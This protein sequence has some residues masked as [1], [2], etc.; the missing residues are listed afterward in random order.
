MVFKT[1]KIRTHVPHETCV[2]E[3]VLLK[4]IL[5]LRKL[6]KPGFE[7]N[8]VSD[9]ILEIP[10]TSSGRAAGLTEG[11]CPGAVNF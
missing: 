8:S 1:F 3:E 5:L 6:N 10:T 11:N 4:H 2:R 9:G 7:V